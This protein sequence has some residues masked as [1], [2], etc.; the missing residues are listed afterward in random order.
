MYVLG[1]SRWVACVQDRMPTAIMVCSTAS[2]NQTA[3]ATSGFSAA[4]L[5]HLLIAVLAIAGVMAMG[6]GGLLLFGSGFSIAP[7]SHVSPLP[8]TSFTVTGVRWGNESWIGDFLRGASSSSR[9]LAGS[10]LLTAVRSFP[11]DA[12]SQPPLPDHA[13]GRGEGA[14]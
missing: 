8:V 13:G 10:A 9:S 1:N 7:Q 2:A 14:A 12:V 11:D 4:T 6:A 5:P 3:S